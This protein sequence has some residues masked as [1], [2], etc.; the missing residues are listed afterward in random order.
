MIDEVESIK[1]LSL[2]EVERAFSGLRITV[3]TNQR[4]FWRVAVLQSLAT[5][6]NQNH[7][8]AMHYAPP[9]ASRQSIIEGV[10]RGVGRV[11]VHE[12]MHQ[13]LGAWAA[14]NNGD[15]N[16]YEYGS[17]GRRSQY[18]GELHWTTARALLDRRLRE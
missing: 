6:R 14:H 5:R 2:V 16:S 7:Q 9:N 8:L 4:A 3:T 18:Y 11:A 12:F 17:P 15:L 13:I 10:G 1:H